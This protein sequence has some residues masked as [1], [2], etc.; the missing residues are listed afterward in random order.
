[1]R[2]KKG[3]CVLECSIPIKLQNT[4]SVAINPNMYNIWG[5]P[6]EEL[7]VTLASPLDTSIVNQYVI[8]FTSGTSTVF[9]IVPSSGTIVWNAPLSIQSNKRYQ[10][11]IIDNL[12]SWRE[13]S[14]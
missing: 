10:I 8:D 4:A 13:F 7:V 14:I 9:N 2:D 6:M 12:A 5:S 11:T 3:L 1:M